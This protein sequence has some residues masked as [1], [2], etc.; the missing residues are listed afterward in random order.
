MLLWQ[1]ITVGNHET[2]SRA[3]RGRDAWPFTLPHVWDLEKYIVLKTKIF[4]KTS[5]NLQNNTW[6]DMRD[7]LTWGGEQIQSHFRC[8]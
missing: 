3:V 4:N 7:K 2:S 6:T 5:K 1:Q 8:I